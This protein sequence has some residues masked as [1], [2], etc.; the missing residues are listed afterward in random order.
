[1]LILPTAANAMTE[2]KTTGLPAEAK[3]DA[4]KQGE[5][6]KE[7]ADPTA[8]VAADIGRASV[9][10]GTAAPAPVPAPVAMV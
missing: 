2:T 6:T 10:A 4:A 7:S 5:V 9:Q 3:E 1:M 8:E